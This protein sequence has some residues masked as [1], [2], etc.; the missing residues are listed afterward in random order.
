MIQAVRRSVLAG[1]AALAFFG[2]AQ[3]QQQPQQQ[4]EEN[5]I[6]RNIVLVH[7]A[8]STDRVGAAFMTR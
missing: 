3:Q 1:L 2:C 7:G 5:Q 6:V 4:I 8:S